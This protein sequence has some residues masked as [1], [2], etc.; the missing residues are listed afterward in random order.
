MLQV[1]PV[2]LF[3]FSSEILYELQFLTDSLMF[4]L[5][6][7]FYRL[8]NWLFIDNVYLFVVVRQLNIGI[9][10]G[11][12][13]DGWVYGVVQFNYLHLILCKK[14]LYLLNLFNLIISLII[15]LIIFLVFNL[16]IIDI[17]FLHLNFNL[18]ELHCCILWSFQYSVLV[19]DHAGHVVNYDRLISLLALVI[20]IIRI[21]RLVFFLI[22][23]L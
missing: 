17:M 3:L 21:L 8:I 23:L 20:V 12:S 16:M 11:K 13:L 7:K 5:C 4:V 9:K 10:L 1:N 22:S 6:Y 19:A 15:I 14:S 18:P 2:F